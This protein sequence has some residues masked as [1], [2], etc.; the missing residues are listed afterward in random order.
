[1]QAAWQAAQRSW[2]LLTARVLGPGSLPPLPYPPLMGTPGGRFSQGWDPLASR[3]GA[4][5]TQ[6][7]AVKP[8]LQPTIAPKPQFTTST[9]APL[10]GLYRAQWAFG[11]NAPMGNT[12]APA[13]SSAAR[14]GGLVAVMPGWWAYGLPQPPEPHLPLAIIS[15]TL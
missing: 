5:Q 7:R 10:G 1:V 9:L 6:A 13:P 14:C 2:D 8:L 4:D 12:R 15:L 11:A 3:R